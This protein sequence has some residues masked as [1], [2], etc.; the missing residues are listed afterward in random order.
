MGGGVAGVG[1]DR[2]LQ[3]FGGLALLT[4]GGVQHGQVVIGLGHVRVVTRQAGED[5]DGLR[6][7]LLFGSDHAAHEAH[8]RITRVLLEVG[9]GLFGGLIRLALV[10]QLGHLVHCTRGMGM[11]CGKNS[12]SDTGGERDLG[13][14]CLRT[15]ALLQRNLRGSR[16][17]ALL[18][19]Q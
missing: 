16:H 4:F 17:I 11:G 19:E 5:L 9:I 6:R 18:S 1:T 14:P 7:L 12:Q 10:E 3:R 15:S 8:L 2:L 13:H